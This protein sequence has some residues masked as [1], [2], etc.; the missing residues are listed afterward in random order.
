[1]R[2]FLLLIGF[3]FVVGC[4]DP[5]QQEQKQNTIEKNGRCTLNF[6]INYDNV[7]L[8]AERLDL[9]VADNDPRVK[10]QAQTLKNACEKFFKSHGNNKCLSEN[11][12]H[13]VTKSSDDLKTL[14]EKPERFLTQ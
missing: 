10:T 8:E 1:M 6:E 2:Y 9:L 12:Y 11:D 3:F 5:V 13:E 7:K 14:C 4:A